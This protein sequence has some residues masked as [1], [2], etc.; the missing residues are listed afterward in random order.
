[1][2]IMLIPDYVSKIDFFDAKVGGTYN[3]H[4][5]EY[6]SGLSELCRNI[7]VWQISNPS[8]EVNSKF[9]IGEL[10]HSQLMKRDTARAHKGGLI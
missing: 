8:A 9:G 7:N 5:K 6:S 4:S 2:E 1:V 10:D 3:S